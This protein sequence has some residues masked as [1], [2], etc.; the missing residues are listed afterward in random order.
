MKQQDYINQIIENN[1]TMGF[2]L[3]Q[4]MA[5]MKS[6]MQRSLKYELQTL[7]AVQ[8]LCETEHGF[9]QMKRLT[10]A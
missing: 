10:N 2:S 1:L 4:I 5:D 6:A 8:E 7:D 9:A 3:E